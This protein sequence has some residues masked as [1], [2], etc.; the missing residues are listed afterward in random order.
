MFSTKVKE[1]SSK[2]KTIDA[3]RATYDLIDL[4]HV[5]DLQGKRTDKMQF[6]LGRC[7]QKEHGH[8]KSS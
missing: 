8:Q 1:S 4:H 7:H 5:L 3:K 6:M 2:A